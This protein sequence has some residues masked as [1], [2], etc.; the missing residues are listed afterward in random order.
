MNTLVVETCAL[1]KNV[2]FSDDDMI[3]SLIDGRTI[4]VPLIWFPRLATANQEQLANYEL[5]GDGEG[6]H[7]PDVDEDISVAGLLRG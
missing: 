5:L 1:A 3:V 4:I 7:W 2:Q 6:I